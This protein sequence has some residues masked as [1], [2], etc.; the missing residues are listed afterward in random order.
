[1]AK[2]NAVWGIDIGQCALKALQCRPHEKDP[3]Q[4]VVESFDYIEY[5]KILSQPEADPEELV[6]EALEQFLERNDLTG[7]RVAISVAG[8]S[9]LARFIKLPPVESKKIPDIVKY[10]ARQQIPFALEDVVWDYQQLSGGSEEDGFALEP[11]VGLFAMKRDQVARALKPFE[12]AG[13]EVDFIQLMPLAIYNFV[14][15]DRL[16]DL[17]SKPYDPEDPPVSTVVISLG[18]DTTDLVVTNGYRVWQRNIPIGGN[19]FTR[20]LSKELKLTFVKAEHLKRNATEADDPKAVFQ[21]MRPVFSDLLSEIQRSLGYFSSIDKTAK[22]GN[23]IALGNAMKLPGLQRYLSQNLEQEVTPIEEFIHLSAGST[24]SQAQFKEN[25]LSFAVS[26]GLCL[27]GAGKSEIRTNLLPEEIVRSRLVRAK[28]PWAVAGIAALLLGMTFNYFMH[29]SAWRDTDTD[30]MKSAETRADAV[31]RESAKFKNDSSEI[32]QSFDTIESIGVNLVSNVEGRL[33]WLE[34]MKAIEASLPKDERPLEQRE[35]TVEDISNRQELHIEAI[36]QEFFEDLQANWFSRVEG[37]YQESRGLTAETGGEEGAGAEGGFEA[38]AGEGAESGD[39]SGPGWVFQLTGYHYHNLDEHK[40]NQ[41]ETFVKNTLIKNLEEGS[42]KLPDGPKGALV[43]VA[44]KDLGISHAWLVDGG[45][46]EKVEIDLEAGLEEKSGAAG[47][48]GG[49][50]YGGGDYGGGGYG[51]GEYGGGTARQ[52][53]TEEGEESTIITLKR[54]DFI[55]QFCWRETPKSVR[56]EN[57][58]ERREQEEAESADT[59]GVDQR[60]NEKFAAKP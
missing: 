26:Y 15:F 36:D 41:T 46:I 56:R 47:G 59:A 12:D 8:Q 33:L 3:N 60:D 25:I 16:E 38:E 48:Y 30:D 1:M 58:A 39:L 11:E 42:V 43:D 20:A 29:V 2:S 4:L 28:K 55:V 24:T 14:C 50:G 27:Q 57:A 6:R 23:M 22:I 40:L 31:K 45:R 13:I 51:G 52:G 49:G 7:D 5:P 54:Y 21:A 32:H 17:Q 35:E 34:L 9:G 44:F 53:G 18:T 19:H 37:S 10:E